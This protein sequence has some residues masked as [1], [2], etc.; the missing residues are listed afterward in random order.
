VSPGENTRS[1]YRQQGADAERQRILDLL[2][3]LK[4]EKCCEDCI[5]DESDTVNYLESIIDMIEGK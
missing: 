3:D 2:K 4:P 5:T 1:Y